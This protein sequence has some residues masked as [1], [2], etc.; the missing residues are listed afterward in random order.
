MDKNVIVLLIFISMTLSLFSGCIE[1]EGGNEKPLVEIT[2]PSDEATVSGLV[3]ISGTASDPDSKNEIK[4]VE[5]MVND[6]KWDDAE[7]T[8]KWSYDWRAYEIEDGTYYIYV[9]SWDGIDYSEVEE[10]NLVIDN[11][12]AIESGAHKWAIFIAAANFPEYN[13][14]K[15]GNGGL[16]LAAVSYTHLTLPTN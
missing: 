3:M 2:Y 9:R 12:D 5:V 13:E 1:E 15:L 10:I 14:S 11:P 8:T 4:R 16:N 6:S 7:G